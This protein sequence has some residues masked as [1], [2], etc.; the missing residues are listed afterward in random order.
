MRR[1][2][3]LVI[4]ALVALP[5]CGDDEPQRFT[6]QLRPLNDSGVEGAVELVPR[7][8]DLLEIHIDATALTPNRVHQQQIHG[9]VDGERD[10]QCPDDE[11]DGLLAPDEAQD[12][13]GEVI[14]DL[15]PYPT[16]GAQGKVDWDLTVPVDP[17]KLRPL[18][19]QV[20]VLYGKM[21]ERESTDAGTIYRR[22]LPVACGAIE[23]P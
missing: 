12:S 13:Y 10:A 23:A 8:K 21:A 9:F 5:A 1:L 16:V 15:A 22:Q 2:L 20:V 18:S 19:D 14:Q 11:G 6:A 4:V 7:E 3:P 17:E